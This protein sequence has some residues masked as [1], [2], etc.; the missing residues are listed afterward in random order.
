MRIY[1]HIGLIYV[2]YIYEY[3]PVVPRYGVAMMSRLLKNI[4][5]VCKI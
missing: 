3:I 4:G 1:I 5:L 2:L